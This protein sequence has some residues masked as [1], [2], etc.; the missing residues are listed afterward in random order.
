[1]IAAQAFETFVRAPAARATFLKAGF[2]DANRTGDATFTRPTAC[3]GCCP[4]TY[5]PRAVLDPAS[6]HDT[7]LAFS[8]ATKPTNV[9]IVLDVS[10][11]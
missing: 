11:P 9:L 3:S 8:A 7:V 5:L 10:T 4:P 6:V 1:M 2:R